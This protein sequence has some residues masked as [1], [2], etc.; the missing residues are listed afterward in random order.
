MEKVEAYLATVPEPSRSALVKLR[1][2]I[3][4]AAPGAEE[5]FGYGLPGFYLDGPLFYYGASKAHCG[6]YGARPPGFEKALAAFEC[7]KGAVRFTPERPLPASLVRRLVRA[8]VTENQEK[9]LA[10][11]NVKGRAKH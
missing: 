2:Q 5:G 11:K 1:D 7:S 10:R 8:R 4:S 9:A 6:L 3:R